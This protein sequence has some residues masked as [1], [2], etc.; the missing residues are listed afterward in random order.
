VR[1]GVQ[2]HGIL[3]ILDELVRL[4]ITAKVQA[5]EGL[6][7]IRA[8]G[9]RLPLEA[10]NDRLDRWSSDSFSKNRTLPGINLTLPDTPDAQKYG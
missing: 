4:D 1:Q 7:K 8:A 9:S 5:A 3:W 2:V 6:R 10:C